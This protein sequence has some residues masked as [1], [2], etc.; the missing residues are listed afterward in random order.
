MLGATVVALAVLF[1]RRE[2]PAEAAPAAAAPP[3]ATQPT[4]PSTPAPRPYVA[5][6]DPKASP[7]PTPDPSRQPDPLDPLLRGLGGLFNDPDVQKSLGDL[8][9]GLRRNAKEIEKLFRG[10]LGP[11]GGGGSGSADPF[12]D[13]FGRALRSFGLGGGSSEGRIVTHVRDEGTHYVVRCRFP[14]GKPETTS[15]QLQGE[16]LVVKARFPRS[17][18]VVR[19]VELPGPVHPLG[20]RSELVGGELVVTLPKAR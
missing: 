9:R 17:G 4:P 10:F 14:H 3:V 6:P 1:L 2:T 8:Q 12:A 11:P 13:F 5:V 7:A 20:A 15:F 18:E 16:K 19:E